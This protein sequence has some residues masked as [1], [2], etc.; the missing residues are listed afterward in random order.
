FLVVVVLAM[1]PPYLKVFLVGRTGNHLWALYSLHSTPP[2]L[3][4]GHYKCGFNGYNDYIL[5]TILKVEN[6]SQSQGYT[7]QEARNTAAMEQ[8][9]TTS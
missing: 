2:T 3:F 9:T 1:F 5:A 4:T 7:E 8:A 6:T